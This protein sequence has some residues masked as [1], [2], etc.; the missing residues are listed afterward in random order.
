MNIHCMRCKE[1][2]K[3]NEYQ[4]YKSKNNKPLVHA[5]CAQ[6]GSGKSKFLSKVEF[7]NGQQGEGLISGLL[8][9]PNGF[10]F[11]KDIPLIGQ[12]I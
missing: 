11:L 6:C 5:R 12:L 3:S 2:T 1:K 7:Q 4:L 8:G 9:Y 10:P